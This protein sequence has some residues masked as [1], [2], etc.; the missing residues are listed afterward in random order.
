MRAWLKVL[1]DRH[2]DVTWI[3]VSTEQ[4][5][6]PNLKAEAHGTRLDGLAESA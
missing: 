5:T 3:P 1:A 6:A 4:A 2:P